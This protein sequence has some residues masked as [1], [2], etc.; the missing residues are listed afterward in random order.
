MKKVL[1]ITGI[2][3]FIH[4]QDVQAQ[5]KDSTQYKSSM[6]YIKATEKTDDTIN[7]SV[8][9][10]AKDI[11]ENTEKN[12]NLIPN[13]NHQTPLLLKNIDS[14]KVTSARKTYKCRCK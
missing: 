9:K 14:T 11:I 4:A 5:T 7:P 12:K 2:I 3:F 6:E 8:K 10:G 13:R 1:A